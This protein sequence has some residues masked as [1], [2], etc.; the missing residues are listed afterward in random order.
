MGDRSRSDLKNHP[1]QETSIDRQIG[2]EIGDRS[3]SDLQG[4]LQGMW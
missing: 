1:N 2:M 4:N 3:R